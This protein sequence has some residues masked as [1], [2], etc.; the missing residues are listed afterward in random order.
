MLQRSWYPRAIVGGFGL[1]FAAA[2]G[3]STSN[4]IDRFAELQRVGSAAN[5]AVS[6]AISEPDASSSLGVMTWRQD[7]DG[8]SRVDIESEDAM[9]SRTDTWIHASGGDVV[10]SNRF[11]GVVAMNCVS[12]GHDNLAA[13]ESFQGMNDAVAPD[14]TFATDG[15]ESF[16]GEDAECFRSVGV[17]R[18]IRYASRIRYAAR[19]ALLYADGPASFSI[20]LH[21]R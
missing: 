9:G 21:D 18:G 1:L 11:P 20:V 7:E 3:G 16:A 12:G 5:F 10:C 13:M 4:P 2:C 6:Y 8:S 19:G 14:S 17:R 15:H